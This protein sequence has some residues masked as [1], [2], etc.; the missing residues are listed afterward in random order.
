MNLE[1]DN[2]GYL[3]VDIDGD[4]VD[5]LLIGSN[6]SEENSDDAYIGSMFTI[7]NGKVC[8]VF[9]S[10]SDRELYNLYEDGV[11]EAYL[12]E[13]NVY[14]SSEYFK[15]TAGKLEFIEGIY[16][17]VGYSDGGVQVNYYYTDSASKK[18]E[19]N[20]KEYHDMGETLKNKYNRPK[21]QLHLFKE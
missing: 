15:Y 3:Q 5:E 20:E 8:P 6:S 13:P 21:I 17:E 14:Y 7:R 1:D 10:Y 19:L 18:H 9:Q 2:F 12:R 16:Q 4:G 11:F